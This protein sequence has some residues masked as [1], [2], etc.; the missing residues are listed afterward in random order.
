TSYERLRVDA[1]GHINIANCFWYP[2]TFLKGSYVLVVQW[3][4]TNTNECFGIAPDRTIWHTWTN[5]GG[6]Q[7]F[8]SGLADD[9]DSAFILS[10]G[11]LLDGEEYYIRSVQVV[12][13]RLRYLA[14]RLRLRL[15]ER[16]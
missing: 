5:A 1:N 10:R 7:R 13:K 3:Y 11:T 4:G 9:T 16:M 15:P 14:K 8:S 2:G 6:W 12:R